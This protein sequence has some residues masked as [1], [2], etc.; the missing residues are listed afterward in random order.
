LIEQL[1]HIP[2]LIFVC[3]TSLHPPD[4]PRVEWT[5]SAIYAA[6]QNMLVAA[7]SIGLGAA[8]TAIH[9]HAEQEV[10]QILAIPE[11]KVLGVTIPLGWPERPFGPLTRKPLSEVVHH[12]G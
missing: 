5:Y 1:E 12:D 6:A 8:F 9:R 7:R 3:G 4:A 11:G 2:V 10:R